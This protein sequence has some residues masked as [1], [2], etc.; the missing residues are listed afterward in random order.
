[1][2]L[3][4]SWIVET[5][6]RGIIVGGTF[7]GGLAIIGWILSKIIYGNS[8]EEKEKAEEN[9]TFDYTKKEKVKKQ[10]AQPKEDNSTFD[11]TKKEKVEK[12][13][14]QPKVAAEEQIKVKNQEKEIKPNP[15]K[16]EDEVL[17]SF[18]DASI[19]IEYD[20]NASKLWKEL[21]DLDKQIGFEFIE[22]LQ[23][24]P[25]QDI[26]KLYADLKGKFEKQKFQQEHPYADP[27]ANKAFQEALQISEAAR[28]EFSK[29]YELMKDKLEP[30]Q[31]LKK[32]K[33]K[34]NKSDEKKFIEP[35]VQLFEGWK[36]ELQKAERS[37][38]TEKIL[39]CLSKLGY[40]T[41]AENKKI[42]RPKLG[43]SNELQQ[44]HITFETAHDLMRV[45]SDER[46]LLLKAK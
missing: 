37:G 18:P 43:D 28:D 44:E 22:Y 6:I 39:T 2:D 1:M 24:D 3:G 17:A 19:I 4:N 46:R 38:K 11:N 42:I 21:K 36:E 8:S 12:Q 35:K 33:G 34:F 5:A 16:S 27:N 10:E 30:D 20:E 15:V 13:E 26:D 9:S 41:D 7:G 23:K 31:I 29:V 14:A 40:K 45:V 25:K 32:I